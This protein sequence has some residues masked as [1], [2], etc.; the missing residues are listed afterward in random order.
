MI[1][2]LSGENLGASIFEIELLVLATQLDGHFETLEN[3]LIFF[4]WI[5]KFSI[6]CHLG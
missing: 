5:I 3:E 1:T 4:L 2:E 6:I